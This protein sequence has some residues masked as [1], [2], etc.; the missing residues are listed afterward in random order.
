MAIDDEP[1]E[2]TEVASEGGNNRMIIFIGAGVFGIL[3]IGGLLFWFLM[4]GDGTE[5]DKVQMVSPQ[6]ALSNPEIL[7]EGFEEEDEYDEEEE[8]LGAIYPMETFIVN[9]SGGQ[10]FLR[11]EIQLEFTERE[12]PSRFYA[13]LVPI[14]DLLIKLLTTRSAEELSSSDGKDELREAIIMAVNQMMRKDQVKQVYF[15]QFIIQ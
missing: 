3:V 1:E 10:R 6:M 12:V 13:R 7:P 11:A 5:E 8:P 15:T 9:L 14:R 2:V 4:A